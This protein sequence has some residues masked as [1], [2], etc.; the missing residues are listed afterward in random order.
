MRGTLHET[1]MNNVI[2][3]LKVRGINTAAIT[4]DY[5]LFPCSLKSIKTVSFFFIPATVLSFCL[6]S[7]TAAATHCQAVCQPAIKSTV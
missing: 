2:Q 3:Q 1:F 7:F 5:S 4:H 6:T